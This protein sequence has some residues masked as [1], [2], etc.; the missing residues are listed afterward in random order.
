[1]SMSPT[2]SATRP[3]VTIVMPCFNSKRV[4]LES[5]ASA[6]AQTYPNTEVVI[7]DDGSTNPETL[8]MLRELESDGFRIVRKENGGVSSAINAGLNEANSGYFLP[9]GDDLID[10]PYV[11]ESVDVMEAHPE[12]GIVYCQAML[13][14]TIERPWRLPP[15]TM[16][17]QLTD[18][19]IF[20]TAL[21]RGSSQCRV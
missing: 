20:A 15:F 13:F 4:L 7:V 1:M 18:N 14:G 17:R 16:K 12:V 11:A 8:D 2:A 21:N 5:I 6:Q 19:C 3:L 10:P 9:L